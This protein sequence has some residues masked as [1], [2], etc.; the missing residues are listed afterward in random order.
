MRKER[1]KEMKKYN[2]PEI[3][4]LTFSSA[5]IITTS[6]GFGNGENEGDGSDIF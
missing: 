3:E 1:Y 2:Q 4:I 6:I 5:D